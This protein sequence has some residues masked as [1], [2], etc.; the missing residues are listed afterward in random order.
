MLYFK[1]G[2]Y[3]TKNIVLYIVQTMFC[4]LVYN[5][6]CYTAKVEKLRKRDIL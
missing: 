1:R 4:V 2:F 3:K 5:V 6:V